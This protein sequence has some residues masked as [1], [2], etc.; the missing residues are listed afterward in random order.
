MFFKTPLSK[1]SFYVLTEISD[2]DKRRRTRTNFTGWQLEEL[3]RA[4]HDSHY[5][6]IFM[7]EAIALKLDLVESRVQVW[8]QNRRA[9]WRKK[10]NTKKSPGRPAHNAHPL[11]CSGDPISEDELRRREEQK[12]LRRMR[13]KVEEVRVPSTPLQSC[14]SFSIDSLLNHTPRRPQVQRPRPNAL[15]FTQSLGFPV[16]RLP[17]P[18]PEESSSSPVM[19]VG[20]KSFAVFPEPEVAIV[21]NGVQSR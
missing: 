19:S 17:T 3:E 13:K 10:E 8:F 20:T 9:K 18:P 14:S 1:S 4:F 16:E 11:T 21:D 2:E 5:P 12:L 7:R 15:S 6:D